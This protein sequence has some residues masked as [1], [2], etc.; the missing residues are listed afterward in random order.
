LQRIKIVGGSAG[1][2]L[3]GC[4]GYYVDVHAIAADRKL[5]TPPNKPLQRTINGSV[6]LTWIAAWRQ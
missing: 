6:R 5:G 1:S 4:L 3:I 2:V